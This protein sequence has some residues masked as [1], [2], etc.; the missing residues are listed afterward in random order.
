MD[1]SFWQNPQ[2]DIA[3]DDMDIRGDRQNLLA[4]KPRT[5]PEEEEPFVYADA[6]ANQ[7]AAEDRY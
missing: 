7:E 2:G 6:D 4:D 3:D 1:H 5:L